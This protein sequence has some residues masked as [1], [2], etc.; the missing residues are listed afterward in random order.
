[1]PAWPLSQR[2]ET[3]KEPTQAR[4]RDLTARTAWTLFYWK[5]DWN[6]KRGLE[7]DLQAEADGID[8]AKVIGAE[9]KSSTEVNAMT[10]VVVGKED[11]DAGTS[12]AWLG[13]AEPS[14]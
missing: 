14:V 13:E 6:E 12:G 11:N 4:R 7:K 8:L 3:A 9:A 10:C 1:M 2:R 5:R